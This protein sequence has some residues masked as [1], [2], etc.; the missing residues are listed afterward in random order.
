M[1]SAAPQRTAINKKYPSHPRS[2][3]FLSQRQWWVSWLPWLCPL[4]NEPHRKGFLDIDLDEYLALLD[5]TGRQIVEG[6]SGAIPDHLAP[7]LKRLELNDHQW[8]ESS[9][10]FASYFYRA[11][12]K[13]TNMA[14]AAAEVGQSWLKGTQAGRTLFPAA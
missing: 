1:D 4:Q 5:W 10:H 12:G 6:K 13:A 11:A 9:Q 3:D 8:L 7:I 14:K 2:C